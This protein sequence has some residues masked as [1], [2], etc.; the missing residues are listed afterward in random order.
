MDVSFSVKKIKKMP[1]VSNKATVKTAIMF[2]ACV[3]GNFRS[4]LRCGKYRPDYKPPYIVHLYKIISLLTF[5]YYTRYFYMDAR[6][7]D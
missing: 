2:D 1:F 6:E 5:L 4:R 3:T 7:H